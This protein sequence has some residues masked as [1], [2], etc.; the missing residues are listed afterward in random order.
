MK[1]FHAARARFRLLFA[2]RATESRM[3][4]E[5]RFHLEMETERLMRDEG[6]DAAE[7]RRRALVAFGGEE[8]HK[9][10]LRDGRGLAWLGGLTLDLKLGA[11]MLGKSPGLTVV[12]GFGMAVAVAI[13]A[14]AYAFFN[15]YYYPDVPLQEG[16]RIVAVAKIDVQRRREDERL[17]HDFLVW[18]RELRSLVDLGAFRTVQRNI[19]GRSGPGEPIELAEMTASGFRLARVPALRGR[20]LADEDEQPGAPPVMVIGYDAWQSRFQ[21][22]P[23]VLGREVRL[24]RT[25]H[26]I[27]GIMPPGFR[28]PINHQYWVPLRID[29]RATIA[30][31][32]GPNLDVFARLAPGAT[33]ASAQAE[34]SVVAR[35]LAADGPRE[36]ARL[37]TRIVPYV[38]LFVNAEA[39]G[40]GAQYAIVKFLT[41]L[42]LVVVATNVAVLVYARTVARTGEIAVRTALGAT[43][44]RIVMQLFAEAL[45]LSAL[46][47][48]VGLGIAAV[49]LDMLDQVLH[50]GF[51]E[52]APFWVDPG[53]SV[54]AVVY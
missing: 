49:G 5:F 53:L 34:L 13:G 23:A 15:S 51:G 20:V 50:E 14:G 10:A 4:E 46:S 26:T 44:G 16:D 17:L 9:E 33:K 43:R 2:R 6:L 29:S 32:A 28:F 7:A 47:A 31:G 24:G 22:D 11:R 18:R 25:V 12:G 54:G 39:Q 45:V 41:A 1:W 27:V 21:G 8:K 37:D 40:E 3:N 52:G 35:R 36:L 38:D 42:L 30:P 19:T 48:L